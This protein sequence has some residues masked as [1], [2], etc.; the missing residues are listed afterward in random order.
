MEFDE[1]EQKLIDLS[2]RRYNRWFFRRGHLLGWLALPIV[3]L[4]FVPAFKPYARWLS[5]LAILLLFEWYFVV[6]TR[7]IGKL[8][9]KVDSEVAD[10][11]QSE[12]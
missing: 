7:V 12:G 9:A 1:L 2:L 8:K 10:P 4:M 3:L 11:P 5:W 6:A